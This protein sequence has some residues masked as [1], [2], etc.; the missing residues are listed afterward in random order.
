METKVCLLSSLEARELIDSGIVPDCSK[1]RHIKASEA[2]EMTGDSP[3]RI[4][5]RPVARWVGT[6]GRRIEKLEE[7]QCWGSYSGERNENCRMNG[8]ALMR[9]LPMTEKRKTL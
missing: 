1:H 7:V 3:S 6:T 8:F 9:K 5:F 2:R 4:Y